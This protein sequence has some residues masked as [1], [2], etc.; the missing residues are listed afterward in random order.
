MVLH[1]P[2]MRKTGHMVVVESCREGVR[3]F[4]IP[5]A[6]EMTSCMTQNV[7]CYSPQRVSL[8]LRLWVTVLGMPE[9]LAMLVPPRASHLMALMWL[10]P[11]WM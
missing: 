8:Y 7:L 6:A 5:S 1:I 9:G 10:H 2:V 3:I 4:S 11:I